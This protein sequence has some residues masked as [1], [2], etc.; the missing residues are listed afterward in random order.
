MLTTIVT[1]A[2][3]LNG[4]AAVITLMFAAV[5]PVQASSRTTPGAQWVDNLYIAWFVGAVPVC[6]ALAVRLG[7]LLPEKI[8]SMSAGL[9]WT[10][11][12]VDT[13]PEQTSE[14]AQEDPRK[15]RRRRNRRRRRTAHHR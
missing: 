3:T 9:T 14:T 4:C 5:P 12:P 7:Q 13:N 2:W 10:G 1:Y 15:H 6:L 11:K 8:R